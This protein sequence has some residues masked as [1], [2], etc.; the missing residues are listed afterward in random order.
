M[1]VDAVVGVL[2]PAAIGTPVVGQ[3]RPGAVADLSGPLR[4]AVSFVLVFVTGAVVLRQR[5]RGIGA[6][7][8]AI[9]ERPAVAVLY[10]VAGY[11]IVGIVGLYGATTLAR[12]SIAGGV[13]V[14]LVVVVGSLFVLALTSFGFLVAGTLLTELSGGRRPSYG[15]VVGAALSAVPWALLSPAG[16]VAVS[17]AVAAF[18]IGGSVRVWIHSERTVETEADAG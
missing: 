18:G 16:S 11:V 12:L 1:S 3:L 15:L 5:R 10:G 9:A 13:L 8:D 17:L 14:R 4:G 7:L 6:A 2:G